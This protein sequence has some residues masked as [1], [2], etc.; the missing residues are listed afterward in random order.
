MVKFRD[1]R[2]VHMRSFRESEKAVEALGLA[3]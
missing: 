1:G 3:P 2:I